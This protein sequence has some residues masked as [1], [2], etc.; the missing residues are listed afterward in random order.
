MKN[1]DVAFSRCLADNGIFLRPAPRNVYKNYFRRISEIRT[2]K[3][4]CLSIIQIFRMAVDDLIREIVPYN[5]KPIWL[6][7]Y[8]WPFV[9]LYGC[10]ISTW[11]IGFGINEYFEA[12]CIAM[13]AVGV[14]QVLAVL[15]CQWF[16]G[17]R[18]WMTCTKVS[19]SFSLNL[20]FNV[21]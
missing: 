1:V 20:R 6:H 14:L 3:V 11:T 18:C 13:A 16:V 5:P 8:V 10:C 21:Y 15:F 17:V 9:I 12:G 19:L 4:D 2:P 7:L